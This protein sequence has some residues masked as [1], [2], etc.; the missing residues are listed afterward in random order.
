MSHPETDEIFNAIVE[1]YFQ[2]KTYTRGYKLANLKIPEDVEFLKDGVN[3]YRLYGKTENF[4]NI[5]VEDWEAPVY[6]STRIE[7]PTY[8]KGVVLKRN[9]D[10]PDVLDSPRAIFTRDGRIFV[11]LSMLRFGLYQDNIPDMVKAVG[12]MFKNPQSAR[13]YEIWWTVAKAQ[14]SL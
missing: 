9:D 11:N 13:S 14:A 6:E 3:E 12:A 7:P 8:C 5:L 10:F 2:C 1:G 4:E